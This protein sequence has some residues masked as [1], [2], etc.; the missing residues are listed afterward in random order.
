MVVGVDEDSNDTL[1]LADNLGSRHGG[2]RGDILGRHE[3]R[4]TGLPGL[5]H[6]HADLG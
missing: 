5:A 2:D 4:A 6:R 3:Y 1:G